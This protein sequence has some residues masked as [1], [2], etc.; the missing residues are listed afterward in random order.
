MGRV[1]GSDSGGLKR[2]RKSR[3]IGCG[4]FGAFFRKFSR[5]CVFLLP[6]TV[7][8]E[9]ASI[10]GLLSTGCSNRCGRCW[11]GASI[12]ISEQKR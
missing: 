5:S 2:G 6:D 8:D 11:G 7:T 3:R 4:V 9:I 10:V 1:G 12:A